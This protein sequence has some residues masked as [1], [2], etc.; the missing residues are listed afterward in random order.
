MDGTPEGRTDGDTGAV[1]A[2]RPSRRWPARLLSLLVPGLG[3]RA[4]GHPRRMV[5]WFG[6]AAAVSAGVIGVAVSGV[7]ISSVLLVAVGFGVGLRI[8]AA[9]DTLRLPRPAQLPRPRNVL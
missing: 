2:D 8:A 7:A 5:A 3:A 1:E 9:A 4:V 6:T